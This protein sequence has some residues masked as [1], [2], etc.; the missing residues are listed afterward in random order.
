MVRYW[1]SIRTSNARDKQV[2]AK[3]PSAL[4]TQQHFSRTLQIPRAKVKSTPVLEYCSKSL[5]IVIHPIIHFTAVHPDQENLSEEPT[6]SVELVASIV[7]HRFFQT[8]CSLKKQL[9]A[10]IYLL[11]IP[12]SGGK[13]SKRLGRII[14][15]KYETS[16]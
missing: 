1:Q 3:P 6:M 10:S 9:N 16:C 7:N 8:L 13:M 14:G 5:V 12:Q 11:S 4:K 15:C 2:E